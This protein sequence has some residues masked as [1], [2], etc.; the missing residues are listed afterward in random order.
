MLLE[1]IS[2]SPK[3]DFTKKGLIS[4]NNKFIQNVADT[5]KVSMNKMSKM[6]LNFDEIYS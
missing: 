4:F 6:R 5:S 1:R 3:T 2:H